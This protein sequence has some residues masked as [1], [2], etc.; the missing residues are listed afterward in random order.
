MKKLL[1][2]VSMA[3]VLLSTGVLSGCRQ[4][5]KTAAPAAA[6]EKMDAEKTSAEHPARQK[7][8]D[9]PAH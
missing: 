3:A 6:E 5:E 2:W 4:E 9:H 1:M 7:P 8:K